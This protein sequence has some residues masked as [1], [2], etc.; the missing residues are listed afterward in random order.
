VSRVAILLVAALI[1]GAQC[2]AACAL[3]P[4][5][6]DAAPSGCHHKQSSSP[7]GHQLFVAESGHQVKTF[8]ARHAGF[9]AIG[10]RETAYGN[11]AALCW[12]PIDHPSPPESA[13]P[14]TGAVLRI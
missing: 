8:V 1:L 9:L 13:C 2:F 3:L 12:E 7:C 11:D 14:I 10:P 4:C 5:T 6:R